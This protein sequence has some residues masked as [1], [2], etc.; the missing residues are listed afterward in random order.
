[1]IIEIGLGEANIEFNNHHSDSF[2]MIIRLTT[3]LSFSNQTTSLLSLAHQHGYEKA[4]LMCF[5]MFIIFILI[6]IELDL[7]LT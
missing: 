6:Q 7:K 5:F 1:M 4:N 2:N 3:K